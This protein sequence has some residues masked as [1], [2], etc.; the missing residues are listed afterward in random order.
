M[1]NMAVLHSPAF[2]YPLPIL[3][4]VL[5]NLLIFKGKILYYNKY[6]HNIRIVTCRYCIF[7]IKQGEYFAKSDHLP[8]LKTCKY[9]LERIKRRSLKGSKE[10]KKRKKRGNY[11]LVIS[12]A[13]SEFIRRRI[14][15]W[16][17]P[18]PSRNMSLVT[19][20]SGVLS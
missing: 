9:C 20:H 8:V 18:C 14:S 11:S 15:A 17:S 19:A 1:R 5:F 12:P 13:K 7:L 4:R 16:L 3:V 6:S 10:E 2:S